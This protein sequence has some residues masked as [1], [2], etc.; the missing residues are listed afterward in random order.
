[1][2]IA[3]NLTTQLFMGPPRAPLKLLS[4]DNVE[5]M[6][7]SLSEVGLKVDKTAVMKM[8]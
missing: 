5:A 8:Y 7:K 2:K 3:M 1:M 4:K 6:A